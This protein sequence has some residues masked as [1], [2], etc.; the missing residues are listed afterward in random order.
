MWQTL[1][2]NWHLMRWVRLGIGIL[3]MYEAIVTL[4]MLV[5]TIAAFF[6]FQ[7]LSNTGCCGAQGCATPIR[8]HLD[9][10]QEIY[11]KEIKKD[12]P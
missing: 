6:L 5:G 7:A 1:F 4:D 12:M 9:D 10:S 11:Y 2:T 3:V 8:N